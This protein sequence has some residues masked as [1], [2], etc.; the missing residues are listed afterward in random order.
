MSDTKSKKGKLSFTSDGF[1][2]AKYAGVSQNAKLSEL[3][4]I[5]VDYKV[6]TEALFNSLHELNPKFSFE[7][8]ASAFD[9]SAD[10]GRVFG[11]YE[12]VA[13]VK[14]GR[15]NAIRSKCSYFLI[16]SGLQEHDPEYVRLYFEKI[17]RFASYPYFRAQFASDVASSGV[18]LPPLPSLTERVD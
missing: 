18:F 17:G 11:V 13:A 1:D 16:Y 12:W 7:G 8:T 15:K 4:L 5:T 14:A 6:S 9:F 3:R 10:D 2:Q